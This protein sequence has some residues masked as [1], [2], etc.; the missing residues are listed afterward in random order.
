MACSYFVHLQRRNELALQDLLEEELV[1]SW[2][3]PTPATQ[4]AAHVVQS[5]FRCVNASQRIPWRC[6][7]TSGCRAAESDGDF[8]AGVAMPLYVFVL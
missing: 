5:A 7:K 3:N 1:E 8:K 4:A 6:K 2:S